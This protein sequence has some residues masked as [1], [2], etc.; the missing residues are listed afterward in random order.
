MLKNDHHSDNVDWWNNAFMIHLC[1]QYIIFTV[2]F[3]LYWRKML[4]FV[5]DPHSHARTPPPHTHLQAILSILIA[6]VCCD[7]SASCRWCRLDVWSR[8]ERRPSS[9][10][11]RRLSPIHTL[12]LPL[13][14]P[15]RG[16]G[17]C[18]AS[19]VNSFGV[20][21][22]S[23]RA[24][25]SPRRH[26]ISQSPQQRRD[27]REVSESSLINSWLPTPGHSV[28]AVSDRKLHRPTLLSTCWDQ[29]VT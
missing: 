27:N 14:L 24:G 16:G 11:V 26:N 3:S 28:K 2:M 6:N 23:A 12:S 22:V 8:G 9:C 20:T 29:L 13:P 5:R 18:D 17:H 4:Y 10:I 19:A 15:F 21:I 25:T 1:S 7:Y